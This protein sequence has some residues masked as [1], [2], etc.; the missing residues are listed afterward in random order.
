VTGTHLSWT[1]KYTK[2]KNIQKNKSIDN[3]TNVN[4][5]SRNKK[6]KEPDS[7]WRKRK[8]E[9]EQLEWGEGGRKRSR[10]S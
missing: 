1:K 2:A 4:T 6:E 7:N 10:C 8:G 3:I 5:K 9:V